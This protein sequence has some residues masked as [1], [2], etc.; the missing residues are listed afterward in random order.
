MKA[1]LYAPNGAGD[2][3]PWNR[4]SFSAFSLTE[5]L[6]VILMIAI[7]AALL[8]PGAFKG[9]TARHRRRLL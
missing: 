9:Q 2:S 8:M 1:Q 7:M 6:V 3:L 4:R 5:L